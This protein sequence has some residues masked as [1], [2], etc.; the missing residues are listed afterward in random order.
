MFNTNQSEYISKIY[1]VHTSVSF[2]I[3]ISAGIFFNTEARKIQSLGNLNWLSIL[4]SV[5]DVISGISILN[6]SCCRCENRLLLK[7]SDDILE[8]IKKHRL[9][10]AMNGPS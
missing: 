9:V 6:E 7:F 1:N 3:A 5:S 4:P 10:A 2:Y 8:K